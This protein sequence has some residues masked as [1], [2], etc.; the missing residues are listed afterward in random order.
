MWNVLLTNIVPF[1]GWTA[2]GA[3]AEYIKPG[4]GA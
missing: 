3:A 2:F 1:V 4:S